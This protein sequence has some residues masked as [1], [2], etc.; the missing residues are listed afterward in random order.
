VSELLYGFNS[1]LIVVVLLMLILL[2]S[3]V[4]YH[5]GRRMGGQVSDGA[6]AQTNT[7][8][9][10]ML[11][12]LALLLGFTFTMALQRFD[13]RSDAVSNEANAI[14]TAYLRS[15]LLPEAVRKEVRDILGT[16]IERRLQAAELDLTQAEQ[17]LD[18][19][20]KTSRLQEQLWSITIEATAIDP[21]PTTT[22]LFIQSLNELIDAY[23]K[24]S[25]S[26]EKHVP[27]IVLLLL[28][29]VFIIA[30]AVLGYAG[31]LAGTRAAV[32]TIAMSVLIVLV[33]FIIIDLDRPRRGIIRVSQES[34]TDLRVMNSEERKPVMVD[35]VQ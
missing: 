17:R 33:I 8:Q 26:L 5:A 15:Q 2:A 12:L 11:G 24:R 31:G 1:V 6:K 35:P 23:G 19:K 22:G 7:I 32:A 29:A 10:A 34:M 30:A 28:F 13:S 27:E 4:G 20:S 3:E 18:E 14:G 16:Y 25:A 9:A 21:R